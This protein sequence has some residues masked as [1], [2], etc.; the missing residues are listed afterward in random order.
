MSSGADSAFERRGASEE[1]VG[2]AVAADLPLSTAAGSGGAGPEGR[3]GH[4]VFLSFV[5]GSCLDMKMRCPTENNNQALV[6][7][8]QKRCTRDEQV[9]AIVA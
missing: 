4:S 5:E 1:H 6:I 2:A 8:F 3:A 9:N 7:V